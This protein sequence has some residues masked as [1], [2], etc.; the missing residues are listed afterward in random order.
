MP[1]LNALRAFESAAR[2]GGYVA[3][4]SE[5][6]VTP[7]AVSQQVRRL[8]EHLGRQLFVR[9]NNRVVMTDAGLAVFAEATRALGDLNRMA[10]RIQGGRTPGRLVVS[11]LPSLAEAWLIPRLTPEAPLID[12]RL[13]P[14][15]VAFARDGIDLRLSYGTGLYPD[16]ATHP[17]F[18]DGVQ[19]MAAPA[20]AALW[21]DLPDDRLIHT[22]WGPGFASHPAWRDWFAAHAPGRP[23]PAPGSGHRIG[24]SFLALEM[25]RRG[26]GVALGQRALAQP[27]IDA[28]ALVPLAPQT[29]PLG[30]PYV[31]VHPHVRARRPSL[32]RMLALLGVP[33]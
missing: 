19:P 11:C 32:Q 1:P 25:A 6:G 8:E 23:T 14:D 33:R 28:G 29:L 30:H 27:M 26:L 17:L 4:A 21:P 5:L 24:G 12:L 10:E 13:E 22:D 31:A 18:H 7:A 15:P 20:L 9:H 16:L 3:A 2:N